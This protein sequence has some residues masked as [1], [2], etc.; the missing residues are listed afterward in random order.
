MKLGAMVTINDSMDGE[1]VQMVADELGIQVKLK[2]KEENLEEFAF[3]AEEAEEINTGE[4]EPRAP[5]VVFMGHVDHGKTSLLDAIRKTNVVKGESGGITQHIGA[6]KVGTTQGMITFIDTPG[7][8]AFTTMRARGAHVTDIVVLIVAADDGLMPQTLEAINHARAA[9]VPIMVAINKMDLPSA[10]ID[11]V[12]RQLTEQ[13]LM[14]E[15]WGGETICCKVSAMTG[16]GLD[17]LLEMISLQAELLELKARYTG[18]AEGVVLESKLDPGRGSTVTVIVQQ[19]KLTKGDPIVC[20]TSFARARSL[21]NDLG[22]QIESAGP[23]EPVQI[24]GFS[25]IPPPGAKFKV[26]I[27][28][29]HARDLVERRRVEEQLKRHADTQK[30]T[31]ENFYRHMANEKY[32]ELAI[33]LKGDTQGTTEAVRGSLERLSGG[34]VK[35]MVIHGGVGDVS[36]NDVMLASA[37]N[38]VVIAFK[39]NIS[40]SV[41]NTA[42]SEGVDIKEYEVIYHATEQ[43]QKAL[44]GML[45]PVYK[46]EKSGVAE[47]RQVFKLSTS[48]IVA[49]CSVLEGEMTRNS[50]A[51]VMRNGEQVYDGEIQSLRRLKD[52]VR[53][54]RTGFECGITM[55]DFNDIREGD[56]IQAYKLVQVEPHI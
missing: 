33:V 43:I 45:D 54:V 49:G 25:E 55:R 34:E 8:E 1:M 26:T 22:E 41:R 35:V 50:K 17:H 12:L 20:G 47:I 18:P 14:P 40:E 46:E 44:V 19:G 5:V 10:N 11:Q 24:L 13:S 9:K 3:A 28:E 37:S 31:L 16:D 6:Y 51:R 27:S 36:E 2:D 53:E 23:G 29:R 38:A 7:H 52:E 48:G 30:V 39:V 21:S 56:L 42:K 4:Q 15:D 32:K